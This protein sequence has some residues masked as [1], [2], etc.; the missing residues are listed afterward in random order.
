MTNCFLSSHF[1]LKNPKNEQLV[2]ILIDARK[3]KVIINQHLIKE[4]KKNYIN[5]TF[6]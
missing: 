4:A 3:V 2:A 6:K 5:H 1:T